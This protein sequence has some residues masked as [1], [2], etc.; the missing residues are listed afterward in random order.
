MSERYPPSLSGSSSLPPPPF[1]FSFFSLFPFPSF[2]D[3]L[4]FLLF[5]P[6]LIYPSLS[7]PSGF[8]LRSFLCLELAA[9]GGSGDAARGALG[10]SKWIVRCDS[11]G[12]P[13][14]DADRPLSWE[15]LSPLSWEYL[16]LEPSAEDGDG[17]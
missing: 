8:A 1:C 3:F 14:R 17:D 11:A 16:S 12:V 13:A 6:S 10:R 7:Y 2:L 5:V 15:Y 9:L 4:S